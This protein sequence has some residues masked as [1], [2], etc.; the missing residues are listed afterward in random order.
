MEN[1]AG[2]ENGRR[3]FQCTRTLPRST[4][5]IQI[6]SMNCERKNEKY[7]EKYNRNFFTASNLNKT[8]EKLTNSRL[9]QLLI[10]I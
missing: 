2:N 8:G 9:D 10:F 1:V 4:A 7:F 5:I 3:V 6:S